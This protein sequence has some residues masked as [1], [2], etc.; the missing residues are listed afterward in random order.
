MKEKFYNM[1]GCN[2]ARI[3]I[4]SQGNQIELYYQLSDNPVQHQWQEFHTNTTKL[5]TQPLSKY[6]T[7]E[8]VEE[9][10]KLL[11]QVGMTITLPITQEYLNS[12]HN[13]FVINRENSPV[14]YDINIYIHI[15]ENT[16]REQYTKYNGVIHFTNDP[17]PEY[18]PIKEEYKL[19]L[20]TE[21]RWGDLL[22]GYATLGKDWGDIARDDDD[23]TDLNVQS[24][25]SPETR[26][27]FHI[28]FP[29]LK[30]F[31]TEFYSWAK[32]KN[33]PLHNLNQLALGRYYLGQIII[34]EELLNF[35]PVASDWYV[36]NHSCKLRWNEHM[37][38]NDTKVIGVYFFNSDMLSL[39]HI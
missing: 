20:T 18:I 23:Q 21:T 25:I 7:D 34:T 22:L 19:W 4:Q 36:P 6:S 37:I 38:G 12:L 33:V 10:G 11:E 14:W 24:T 30:H 27:F 28:H 9:L 15:A 31:E 13:E 3:T 8:C 39:I 35:H 2:T 32:D 17:E 29:Q 1:K 16:L 26:M 5:I